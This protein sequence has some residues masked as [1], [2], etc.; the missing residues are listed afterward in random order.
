LN[1]CSSRNQGVTLSH[2]RRFT[3]FILLVHITLK[4]HEILPAFRI[5]LRD[6]RN[7]SDYKPQSNMHSKIN[8]KP[9]SQIFMNF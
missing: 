8:T 6:T 5:D 1:Q 7:E 2:L 9:N 4:I 3:F